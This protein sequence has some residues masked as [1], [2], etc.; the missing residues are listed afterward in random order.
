MLMQKC[1]LVLNSA[2][3]LS[4][5]LVKMM[6]KIEFHAAQV[7]PAYC[8]TLLRVFPALTFLKRTIFCASMDCHRDVQALLFSAQ[9]LYLFY[10]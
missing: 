4:Y 10:E 2:V 1:R 8:P 3:S 9:Y 6:P 5:C 7:L